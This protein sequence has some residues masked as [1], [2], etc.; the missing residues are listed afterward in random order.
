MYV[1]VCFNRAPPFVLVA[2]TAIYVTSICVYICGT[3]SAK[4]FAEHQLQAYNIKGYLCLR[5]RVN[6]FGV[7]GQNH[8][9]KQPAFASSI[10]NACQ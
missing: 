3:D 9:K 6:L 4:T 10:G 2:A 1:G 8:G 5:V 7:L